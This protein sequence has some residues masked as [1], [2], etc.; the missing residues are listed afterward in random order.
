MVYYDVKFIE[1]TNAHVGWNA[2]GSFRLRRSGCHIAKD[3]V[4]LRRQHIRG[5]L[6][7]L[8]RLQHEVTALG[9]LRQPFIGAHVPQPFG[10]DFVVDVF[11]TANP[12][13]TAAICPCVV[14]EVETRR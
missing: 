4:N 12:A 2:A 9:Q 1:T 3:L 6:T 10:Q 13:C 5:G 7:R 11:V 14:V 8:T